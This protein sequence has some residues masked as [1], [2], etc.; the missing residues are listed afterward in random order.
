MP[1]VPSLITLEV[2]AGSSLR[3]VFRAKDTE[4]TV[5]SIAPGFKARGQIRTQAGEH[6]T[7]GDSTL[8]LDLT[9]DN[10]RCYVADYEGARCVYLD[11]NAQDTRDCNEENKRQ[12]TRVL[13]IELYSDA[14]PDTD[15][16][17]FV[18]GP[19]IVFS[20]TDRRD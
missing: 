19:F 13:G 9:E 14:N 20:E 1:A 6:G 17:A 11:L 4:G 8:V 3:R 5:V 15:V 12:V 7:S 10:G 16:E 2:Q 18:D